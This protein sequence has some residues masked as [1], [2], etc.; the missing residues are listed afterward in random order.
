MYTLHYSPGSCSLIIHCL[1]EELGVPFEARKVD[2]ENKEHHGAEYRKLNP[3]GK[4]PV[5][6]TPDGPLTECL[7]LIEYLCDRHDAQ[8]RWLPEPG[9]WQRAR[10]MERLAMLSTEVHN[11]LGNRFFHPDGFSGDAA[12]QAAVKANGEALMTAFFRAE[13]ARLAG[14]Y[15]SGGEK[16]DASDL[17][18]MVIARWGRWLRDS[19]LKMPNIERFFRRMSERPAVARAMQREGIKPFGS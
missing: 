6:V 9:S 4:V 19:A 11:N 8:R 12:V 14:G 5:L 18:F 15:W 2:V 13:D 3:K 16:P 1:L 17:F 10:A 7:A